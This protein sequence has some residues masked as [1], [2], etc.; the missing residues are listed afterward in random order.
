[1]VDIVTKRNCVYQTAYHVIWCPK[2]RHDILTGLVAE[3]MG[4]MLDAIC[5]ERGWPMISK[6]IQPDHVHLFVSI[7]PALAV[8]DAVKIL[9][10]TTARKLFQR[11]PWLKNRLLDGHLWSPS[12][13]VGT[14]GNV[15][16]ETIRRYIERSEHVTKRR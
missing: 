3:E 2:Y 9:K 8:A 6:E 7:P 15:S 5:A 4:A 11:F 12:Y 10:G 16:A 14:A 1:M 13:Y